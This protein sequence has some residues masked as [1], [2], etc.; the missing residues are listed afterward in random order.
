M[1]HYYLSKKK[2]IFNVFSFFLTFLKGVFH[3]L[4][5]NEKCFLLMIF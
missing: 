5:F 3:C 4:F 2:R 1:L